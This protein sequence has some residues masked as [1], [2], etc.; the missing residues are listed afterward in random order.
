M[1]FAF[2]NPWLYRPRWVYNPYIGPVAPVVSYSTPYATPVAINSSSVP[3]VQETMTASPRY[4][5]PCR[6]LTVVARSQSSRHRR[7]PSPY[8]AGAHTAI[9][10]TVGE[11]GG[12]DERRTV[13]M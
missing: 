10:A 12:I 11:K 2:V 9:A 5:P 1:V 13:K 4:S 6:H 7:L 8:A 3:V